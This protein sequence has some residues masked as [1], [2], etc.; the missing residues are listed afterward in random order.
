MQQTKRELIMLVQEVSMSRRYERGIS[1]LILS[2]IEHLIC[3][4]E[5]TD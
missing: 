1:F 4:V 3:F 2:V 5:T